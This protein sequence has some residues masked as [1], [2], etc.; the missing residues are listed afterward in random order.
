MFGKSVI[1]QATSAALAKAKSAINERE[2]I[3]R[4]IDE[5]H[6]AIQ[7]SKEQL[8]EALAA[9]GEVSAAAA[10]AAEGQAPSSTERAAQE[11]ISEIKL[12]I[13][14]LQARAGALEGRLHATDDALV[15]VEDE[16]GA[17]RQA[18]RRDRVAAFSEQYEQG[19]KAFANILHAGLALAA[20]L[21]AQH[22]GQKLRA[23]ILPDLTPDSPIDRQAVKLFLRRNDGGGM[24]EYP[25]WRDISAAAAVFEAHVGP[26]Q[27]A[28][29]LARLT[30]P[31]R[32]GK[33]EAAQREAERQ[34]QTQPPPADYVRPVEPAEPDTIPQGSAAGPTICPHRVT[35]L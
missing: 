12:R 1:D 27:A 20:A 16:L 29:Q 35:H 25:A 11:Q 8:Q 4:L 15:L 13:D 28:E 30:S 19:V 34:A 10:L 23:V 33:N 2:K 6:V 26:R 31:I 32:V 5:S 7:R 18:W 22:L 21:G 3:A 9:L 17:A 14:V 24:T